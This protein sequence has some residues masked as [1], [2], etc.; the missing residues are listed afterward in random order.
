MKNLKLTENLILTS[1]E[2]NNVKAEELISVACYFQFYGKEGIA[3]VVINSLKS[4]YPRYG[5]TEIDSDLSDSFNRL[6]EDE[7]NWKKIVRKIRAFK[8]EWSTFN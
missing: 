7:V 8:K 3:Y 2:E 4:E 5:M 1:I 6:L